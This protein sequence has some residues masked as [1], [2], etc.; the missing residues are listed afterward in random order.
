VLPIGVQ[1]VDQIVFAISCCSC[2]VGR[3][4]RVRADG[5]EVTDGRRIGGRSTVTAIFLGGGHRR[6]FLLVIGTASS[7]V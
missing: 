3:H 1:A 6:H 4:G 2:F 7:N 5:E